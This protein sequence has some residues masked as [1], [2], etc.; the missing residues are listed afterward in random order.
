MKYFG[1]FLLIVA[2]AVGLVMYRMKYQPLKTDNGKLRTENKMWRD[3]VEKLKKTTAETTSTDTAGRAVHPGG[4]P[5][6]F[7]QDDLFADFETNSFTEAGK[8]SL[9]DLADAWKSGKGPIE[10]TGYTDN[11]KMGSKLQAKYPTNWELAGLRAIA[12]VKFLESQGI[13]RSRL[14]ARSGGET[15]PA[16]DN[17]TDAGRKKNRRIEI[18]AQPQ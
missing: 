15:N 9:Q 8:K 7:L 1:W 17:Q 18:V 5:I 16:A 12:V 13:D 11:V 10:V 14:S 6:V 3:E 4:T 2:V